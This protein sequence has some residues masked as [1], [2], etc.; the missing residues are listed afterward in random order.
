MDCR[1]WCGCDYRVAQGHPD[2]CGSGDVMGINPYIGVTYQRL[3]NSFSELLEFRRRPEDTH[4]RL[5]IGAPARSS[6][7]LLHSHPPS[8][9]DPI[10]A[11]VH[12]NVGVRR[13]L[14]QYPSHSVVAV[15]GVFHSFFF[16]LAIGG[17]SYL[18]VDFGP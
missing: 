6:L 13:E 5:S 15:S 2:I 3:I 14:S 10:D 4:T 17:T 12:R 7:R 11:C 16:R 1:F 18:D 8:D 9:A